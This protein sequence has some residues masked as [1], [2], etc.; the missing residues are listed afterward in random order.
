M[1]RFIGIDLGGT[2]VKLGVVSNGRVVASERLKADSASGLGRMLEPM[3]KAIED[4][5]AR[6]GSDHLSGIALAFPGIVDFRAKRAAA[7][8]AKYDDAP[9]I[10]MEKWAADKFGVGF[11]MDNDARMAMIGEWAYGAGRGSENMVMM[12]IGTGIGTGA[13]VDSRPL[14]GRNWCAGSLGG[15]F[16]VDYR[17]RRCTCGNTGCVEAHSSSFFLPQ[18]I[19]D[20][21]SSSEEFRRN[22]SSMDFKKLFDLYREGHPDARIVAEECMDVWSAAVVNYIHAYDPEKVVI[23]GGIMKSAD[24]IL[25]YLRKKVDSMA[26][27][28]GAKVEIVSSSLGDDAALLA[29]EYYFKGK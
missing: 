18:I 10:D 7:T 3:E 13:I 6:T 25:P 12:T 16:T 24:I 15:H 27:N 28:P 14:Y 4:L 23:G 5:L 29:T 11:V 8:N 2:I 20:M 21:T 1:S 26:W 22:A 19:Q 9:D 17:G